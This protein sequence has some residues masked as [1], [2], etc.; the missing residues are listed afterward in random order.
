MKRLLLLAASLALALAGTAA[1][2][3][4][5]PVILQAGSSGFRH[6]GREPLAQLAVTAADA[7]AGLVGVHLD[8]KSTLPLAE[9]LVPLSGNWYEAVIQAIADRNIERFG[10]LPG[11]PEEADLPGTATDM[12]G[13]A[14]AEYPPGVASEETNLMR[15][16]EETHNWGSQ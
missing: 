12:A 9:A 7:S 8:R 4:G 1:E 6:A 10:L 14:G 13:R 11:A 15:L 3:T 16:L 2:V 5:L